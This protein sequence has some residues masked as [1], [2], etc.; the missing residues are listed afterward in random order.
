MNFGKNGLWDQSNN[1]DGDINVEDYLSDDDI[2][3]YKLKSNNYSD[4]DEEKALPF[5]SV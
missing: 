1:D 2:P 3:D 4:D 5:V